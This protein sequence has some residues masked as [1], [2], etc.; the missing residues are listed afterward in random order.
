MDNFCYTRKIRLR[1]QHVDYRRKLRLT[2]LM[3]LFQECCIAHTEELG[4][5]RERTLDRG[6]LWI[7]LS[8]RFQI[9]RLPEYDEEITLECTPGLTLHFF[10]PRNMV[11]KDSGGNVIIRVHAMWG[12]LDASTR[13]M[14]DPAEKGVAI[15]GRSLPTDLPPMMS[16]NIPELPFSMTCKAS[17]SLVDI[18]GHLNNA[19][20]L[21]LAMDR[22]YEMQFDGDVKEIS[23]LF[24]KEI[25]FMSEF[26]MKYGKVDGK[27][28]F[29]CPNYSL[30][31]VPGP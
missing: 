8:E 11:V 20:Y 16:F 27:W 1:S 12:L 24:R 5:G 4:M 29:H 30:R 25:P 3:R 17:Y 6:L 31:I 23:M 2:E 15:N 21:G 10:F 9:E 13:Q 26:N 18:N 22:L 28:F 19:A 14:V 7:V